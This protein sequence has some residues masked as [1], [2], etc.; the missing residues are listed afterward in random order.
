MGALK[1]SARAA[2]DVSPARER[3]GGRGG[4]RGEVEL[5]F[6]QVAHGA[7]H[8]LDLGLVAIV[9]ALVVALFAVGCLGSVITGFVITGFVIGGQHRIHPRGWECAVIP[10]VPRHVAFLDGVGPAKSTAASPR[11]TVE[12]GCLCTLPFLLRLVGV[13]QLGLLHDA[14]DLD[15]RDEQRVGEVDVE[16]LVGS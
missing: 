11:R 14:I 15:E 3:G 2:K 16:R 4:A 9:V 6:R 5:E 7:R 8:E 1:P 12:L 13:P 10:R